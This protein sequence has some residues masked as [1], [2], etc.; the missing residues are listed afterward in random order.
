[1]GDRPGLAGART[2]EHAHRATQRL[3]DLALLGV[4]GL[5]QLL[6]SGAWHQGN[7]SGG[8][9]VVVSYGSENQP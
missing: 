8:T 9:W 5:E 4:E 7:I 2:S 3:G 6:G 1:M